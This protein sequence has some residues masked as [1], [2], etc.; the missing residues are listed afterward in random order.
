MVRVRARTGVDDEDSVRARFALRDARWRA[1]ATAESRHGMGRLG[2][3]NRPSASQSTY[4]PSCSRPPR[5]HPT[6]YSAAVG[7]R[8]IRGGGSSSTNRRISPA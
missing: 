6:P 4:P 3:Y 7:S 1:D 8:A 5:L 2:R